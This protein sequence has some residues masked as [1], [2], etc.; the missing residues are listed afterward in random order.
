VWAGPELVED[1]EACLSVPG[2]YGDVPRHAAVRVRALDRT[3]RRV[4]LEARDFL[5]RVM[6]HEIDHLD[7]VLFIDRVTGI[8]KLYSLRENGNGEF[9]RVPYRPPVPAG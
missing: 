7:G 8:D 3:G 1:Q 6:Q 2:L 4:E 9:V 5:A